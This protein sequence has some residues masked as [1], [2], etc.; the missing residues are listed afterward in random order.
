MRRH[1]LATAVLM[2]GLAACNDATAPTTRLAPGP[3]TRYQ[4]TAAGTLDAEIN[5]LIA[6]LFPTGLETAAGTRWGS[7]KEKLAAGQPLVAKSKLVELTKWV[8]QKQS[9][10]DSPPNSESKAGAAARLVLYMSL[11]VYGGPSTPV[12]PGFGA[13]ADATVGI[14]SPT[15]PAVIQT[16]ALH[17]AASFDAG[18]VNADAIVVLTQ[19][20]DFFASHCAG[21]MTTKYCQYPIFYHYRVFPEQRF[22]K[23]VH[24]AMCHVH[25]G[26]NYGPL[27]GVD[28][29]KF[30]VIHDKPVDDANLTPGGYAVPGENTEVLPLNPN[31]DPTNPKIS[32]SGT[33]YGQRMLFN[34]PR[35]PRGV[36]ENARALA[37]RAVNGAARTIGGLLTPQSL[38]AIDNGVEHNTDFFSN[39]EN[40]DTLG[41]PD[42]AVSGSSASQPAVLRGNTVTVSYTVS[43]AGTAPSPTVNTIVRLTPTGVDA[44]APVDLPATLTPATA[45]PLYPL[46]NYTATAVATIPATTA[47]GIYAISVVV[48]SAGGLAERED[49]L[50]NNAQEVAL[51]VTAPPSGQV[52][53]YGPTMSPAYS[54]FDNEQTLAQAAGLT[55]GVADAVT[56]S[57]MRSA[58]FASYK[59]IVFGDPTCGGNLQDYDAANAN[60]SVW[61][62]V[63]TGPAIVIGTDPIFHQAQMTAAGMPIDA[64][65][66]ITNGINYAA[67]GSSTGLYVTLSC[68]Y[69]G[70]SDGT[71]VSYLS[72]IGTFQVGGQGGS[73]NAVTIVDTSHPAMLGLSN[74]GLSN[75]SE[76]VHAFF[77]SGLSSYPSTFHELASGLRPS[78]S[79][80]YPYII[81]R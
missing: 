33:V 58:D 69:A 38:Y 7:I 60:K 62:P 72:G 24:V 13:G 65:R 76:S 36:L 25:T 34:V 55:V 14:V 20:T 19:N 49:A 47:A 42:L 10:M 80:S 46:D 43:N 63:V 27:P 9:Q 48:S 15:A 18:S 30:V 50:A 22:N 81:A 68:Y 41:H 64:K 23:P 57:T 74:G 26:T 52:L 39:I 75:W 71:I 78:N 8:I 5:A 54:G 53:I 31:F 35:A 77:T 70:A 12:P 28:H 1:T 40:A 59:A 21:P 29:D 67:S 6:A 66:L 61:S 45:G 73:A 79:T 11:Y 51:Q 32:C 4:L 37:V 56:W 16:P 3:Q 17:A 44:S 2:L